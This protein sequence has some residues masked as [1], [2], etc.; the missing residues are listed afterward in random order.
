VGS[1]L[2]VE[3][4]VVSSVQ[5]LGQLP[6]RSKIES[7]ESDGVF[8]EM[9]NDWISLI[10]KKRPTTKRLKVELERTAILDGNGLYD[11]TEVGTLLDSSGCQLLKAEAVGGRRRFFITEEGLMGMA[12]PHVVPGDIVCVFPGTIVP[13]LLR[14]EGSFYTLVGEAYVSDGYM[15]GRAFDEMEQGKRALQEFELH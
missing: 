1:I 12:P 11:I 13:L 14:Q 2:F 4:L 6:K 7:R 10:N 5:E 15:E 9:L 3:G 8:G